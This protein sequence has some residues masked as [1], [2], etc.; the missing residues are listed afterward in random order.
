MERRT[1]HL[2]TFDRWSQ[3]PIPARHRPHQS[4]FL[5]RTVRRQYQRHNL[6]WRFRIFWQHILLPPRRRC[7]RNATRARRRVNRTT[8]QQLPP[9]RFRSKSIL[10]FIQQ[11]GYMKTD[12]LNLV[13]FLERRANAI[14]RT[15]DIELW[16]ARRK[17]TIRFRCSSKPKSS[18][19]AWIGSNGVRW[20]FWTTKIFCG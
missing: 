11:L 2:C 19:W 6:R 18:V 20:Q 1:H 4:K 16:T 5:A 3:I 8:L 14:Y 17:S 7:R 13:S 12:W 15:W 9:G 10:S